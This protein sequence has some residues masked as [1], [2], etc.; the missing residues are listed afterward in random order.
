MDFVN[1]NEVLKPA[2]KGKFA[3]G[4]FNFYDME[5]V[6]AVVE[7]AEEEKSPVILI[8][9][10]M[11]VPLLG[12]EGMLRAARHAIEKAKVP[13]CVHLDHYTDPDSVIAFIKAGYPSV[14]IDVSKLPFEENIRATKRVVDEAH[15]RGVTVEGEL[16]RIG[17][18]DGSVEESS[19]NPEATDP[20]KALEFVE[21]TKV[22]ALAIN[23]GN[24]H[25]IYKVEPKLNFELLEKV[26]KIVPVPL[27][28]HGGSST[29]LA[30]LKKVITLGMRK[31][32]VATEMHV[33]FSKVMNE[34]L[35]NG[36]GFTWVSMSLMKV[37]EAQKSLVR[38]WI[39]N[40]GS[41][42]SV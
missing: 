18:V 38:Q 37:K 24:A 21:R 8:T 14:M 20:D 15:K 22:D 23:I 40:L 35:K 2:I 31:V 33:A 1:L 6:Q 27:V 16:G 42:G 39:K 28:M 3:I 10:P 36:S 7:T 11:E 29:P 30:D 41:S 25:G 13:V 5:T 26:A 34:D 4:A 19:E 9:G 32:N 12:M 17:M